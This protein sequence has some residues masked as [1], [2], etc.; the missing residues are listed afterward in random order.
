MRFTGNLTKIRASLD[1][2]IKRTDLEDRLKEALC[3]EAW[4][5]VVGPTNAQVTKA[6]AILDGIMF[7]CVKNSA[8]AQELGFLK[9]DIIKKINQKVGKNVVREIQFKTRTLKKQVKSKN[10][11]EKTVQD[12]T[13]SEQ[14]ISDLKKIVSQ[15]DDEFLKERMLQLLISQKKLEKL[16]KLSGWISCKRCG[17]LHEGPDDICPIC[18]M[19]LGLLKK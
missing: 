14:E 12:I 7:V 6:D 10:K 18:K 15:E 9:Q 8:W 1:K 4:D 16:K 3:L 19:E 13:L 11:T 17:S 5:D 2:V